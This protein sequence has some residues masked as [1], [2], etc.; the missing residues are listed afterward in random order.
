VNPTPS[1][2]DPIEIVR[3]AIERVGVLDIE[4]A[5]ELVADDFVLELPFRADG[6]PRR[7]EAGEAAAFMRLLPKLF[8]RMDFSDVAVHGALPDGTVVAE[9]RSDGLTRSGRAYPNRYVAMFEVG[10]G[11]I[12]RWREFF[13]P[14]VVS[15]A[16]AP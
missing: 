7:M 10:D 8:T 13:D 12:T 4:G 15:A 6:G 16:F 2:R 11:R 14:T 3:T 5:L 9:Y 1:H